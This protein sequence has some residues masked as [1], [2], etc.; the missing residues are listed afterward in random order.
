MLWYFK[1][2]IPLKYTTVYKT[3]KWHYVKW[4]MFLGKCFNIKDRVLT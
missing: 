4:W 1:Q 2:L 3:E